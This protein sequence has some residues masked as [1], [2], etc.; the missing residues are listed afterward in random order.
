MCVCVSMTEQCQPCSG[1]SEAPPGAGW[2]P[3]AHLLTPPGIDPGV[4]EDTCLLEHRPLLYAIEGRILRCSRQHL[5]KS[6]G[7]ESHLR[8][9]QAPKHRAWHLACA[10][11]CASA[12]SGSSDGMFHRHGN[13]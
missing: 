9:E 1:S 5:F 8:L 13:D 3:M 11:A 4:V 7:G 12:L 10:A 6:C 2:P